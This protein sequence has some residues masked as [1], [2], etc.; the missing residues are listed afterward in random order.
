VPVS[1][2]LN[3]RGKLWRWE[4]GTAPRAL[5][6]RVMREVL[7][8]ADVLIGNEADAEDVLGIRAGDSQVESGRLDVAR[9]PEVAG[10]IAGEFPGLRKI[11]ITLRESVSADWNRWGAMLYDTASAAACFAPEVDGA[12]TPFEIRDIVDRV[13]AGDAFGA[14]LIRILAGEPDASDERAVSFA[15]AAGC[16][17]HSIAGDFNPSTYEEVSALAGGSAS[18]RVVR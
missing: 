14:G 4:P 13:G 11:A 18:G 1:V 9:Y 15:V 16:L 12:Y 2:D 3:F 10:R 5:A 6:G 17:A 7:S 8:F